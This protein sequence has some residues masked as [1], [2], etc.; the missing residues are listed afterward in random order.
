MFFEENYSG[1]LLPKG[2]ISLVKHR[3]TNLNFDTLSISLIY[4]Q[5]D[6]H[7]V[8]TL[9]PSFFIIHTILLTVLIIFYDSFK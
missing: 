3:K 6:D 9:L 4:S 1:A 8:H 7:T 5:D 2:Y